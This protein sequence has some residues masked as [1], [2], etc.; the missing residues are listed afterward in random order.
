MTEDQKRHMLY[1]LDVAMT[2]VGNAEE[3]A[4]EIWGSSKAVDLL[5]HNHYN[6][7]EDLHDDISDGTIDPETGEFT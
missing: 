6:N 2:A 5:I 4:I 7:I 1:L 3:F